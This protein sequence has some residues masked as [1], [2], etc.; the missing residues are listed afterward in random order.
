MI[1]FLFQPF[2]GN[3]FFAAFVLRHTRIQGLVRPCGLNAL[4]ALLQFA[5][6][7]GQSFEDPGFSVR[8]VCR[9]VLR[10]FDRR[11]RAGAVWANAMAGVSSMARKS[12]LFMI[13]SFRL[14]GNND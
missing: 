3:L 6:T 7:G 10:G 4:L 14:V 1:A 9:A 12:I 5:G 11:G 8:D 2:S 13:R